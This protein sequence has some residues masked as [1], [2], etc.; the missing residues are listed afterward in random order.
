MSETLLIGSRGMLG[1]AMA[2]MEEVLPD[3][4]SPTLILQGS[5]DPVVNPV[6]AQLIFDKIGSRHKELAILERT[7]HG[8]VNGD[9][10]ND[11]FEPVHRFIEWAADKAGEP[12]VAVPLD[13]S[14]A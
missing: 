9:G 1:R 10:C 12:E 6:S 3:I 8:I 5:R 7:R 11:V 14:V 2:A 13:P 4:C